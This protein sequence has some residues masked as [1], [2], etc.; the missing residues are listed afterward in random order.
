MW[1]AIVIHLELPCFYYI[2][3]TIIIIMVIYYNHDS[4]QKYV[5]PM[6]IV[7]S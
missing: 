5:V 4:V 2:I 1:N 3:T 7:H 6:V